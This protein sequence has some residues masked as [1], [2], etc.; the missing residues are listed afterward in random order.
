MRVPGTESSLLKERARGRDIRVVYFPFDALE[1]ARKHPDKKIVFLGVGFET[2]AP[3]I[4][5]SVVTAKQKSIDNLYV[6]S[7]HKLVPPAWTR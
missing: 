5:A 6:Y 3:I 4:A 1:T 2:P 7:A